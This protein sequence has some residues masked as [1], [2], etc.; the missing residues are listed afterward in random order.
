MSVVDDIKARLDLVDIVGQTVKL[1]RTGRNYI[2]FCPFHSNTR[3]P[4]FVV[5]PETQTWRCF[6][7]CNEGG[8]LF[9]YMM[10]KEGWD[11]A[12]TLKMLAERAGVTL[13][14]MAQVGTQDTVRKDALINVLEDAVQFYRQQL[15]GTD[16]GKQALEYLHKRGLTD[17]TIKIWGLGYAP[18]AWDELSKE[19]KRKGHSEQILLDAGL[20][21]EREGGGGYDKFRH[22][23]MFPI[24]DTYGKMAG[25]GGRVLNPDDVPKYMNSPRTDLFDK[26]RI[27]YGLDMARQAIRATEQAV[28]VEGYMDVIGLHQAGFNNAVSPMGTALTED[29]FRL[30]KKF[31]RNIILALDPDAA[32]EKATLRGLETARKTMDE[33][34]EITFDSKGLLHVESRVNADIRVTT[35]PNGRD[36]DEIVLADGEAWQ[37]IVKNARPVVVHV[38]E[39]LA[40]GQNLEDAKVKREVAAQ[41]LPLIDDVADPVEREAY[42]QQLA[43]LIRVD[44]RALAL[45]SQ[46]IGSGSRRKAKDAEPTEPAGRISSIA[47]RNRL[48]EEHALR[49]LVKQPHE[50]YLIN[51]SLGLCALSPLSEEDFI[52]GDFKHYFRLLKAALEQQLVTAEEYLEENL[53]DILQEP[54]DRDLIEKSVPPS[55][56]KIRQDQ[57]R[58]ILRM[59][60]NLA[61]ERIQQ[62]LMLQAQPEGKHFLPEEE[63]MLLMEQFQFLRLIDAA[64]DSKE[65]GGTGRETGH[66]GR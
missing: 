37:T 4:A 47:Q 30:L 66:K 17:E 36:P 20:L 48:M 53:P 7:Q 27:L 63:Q 54:V 61:E 26:G 62:I 43:R 32:G 23:L 46:P 2:G 25:F 39:T 13:T 56:D 24:R 45:P 5:F 18:N 10:K 42:R 58:N 14:P 31:T 60:R 11:F 52:E 28:I 21:T 6:G 8:D 33:E 12:E 1:R 34:G 9:G 22:R 29:Q 40:A 38:M 55:E 35:L 50:L 59:R 16:A 65:A 51:R 44:E 19:L 15:V 49:Y 64:M 3:T 41:V 57:V